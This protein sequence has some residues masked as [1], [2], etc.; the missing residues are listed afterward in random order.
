M[1]EVAAIAERIMRRDHGGQRGPFTL[2]IYPTLL[3]N[4]ACKF[5]DTTIR[6]HRDPDELSAERQLQL[7]DEAADLGAQRV[8]VLGGGE[9]LL[10]PHTPALLRRIKARGLV[11]MLTTNGTLLTGPIRQMLV[12]IAWDEVHISVDGATPATHD[13]LRGRPG[14]FRKTMAAVC[15]LRALRDA[16]FVPPKGAPT[17]GPAIAHNVR[18]DAQTDAPRAQKFPRLTLHCVLTR[19]NVDELPALVRL[20]AAVGAD[21]VELD[22]LVAYRPEQTAFA[23]SATD[24]LRLPGQLRQGI[25]AAAETGVRT[26]FTRFLAP[27][28]VARGTGPPSAGSGQGYAKAPCLKPWHHLVISAN[29]NLSPC[30]VLAGEGESVAQTSLSTAW[31]SSPYLAKLRA[32]ML[33]GTPGGRCAECSE[34]I[35]VHERNIRAELANVPV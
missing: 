23:L 6:T 13:R 14:A 25:A 34:N 33:A 26:N 10:A 27:S 5:C 9:P 7:I 3:C 2:E 18:P 15:R 21:A 30:C 35:L 20:A 4:L 28:S 31:E 17:T 12:E 24:H 29:G 8:M 19:L 1:N 32:G 16:K 11:G 22:A